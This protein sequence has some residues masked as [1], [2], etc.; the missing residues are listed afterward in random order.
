MSTKHRNSL[1][2]ELRNITT[3]GLSQVLNVYYY[4]Y[5]TMTKIDNIFSKFIDLYHRFDLEVNIHFG[6]IAL[7]IYWNNWNHLGNLFHQFQFQSLE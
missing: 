7:G 6:K 5:L 4:T 2:N 1:I 3:L